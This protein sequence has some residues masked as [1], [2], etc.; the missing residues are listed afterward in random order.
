M[1]NLNIDCN[2]QMSFLPT[3]F[4]FLSNPQPPTPNPPPPIWVGGC[5][6]YRKAT[7]NPPPLIWVGGCFVYKKAT[8]NPQPPTPHLGGGLLRL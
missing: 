6:V 2:M 5:F 4:I 3:S 8:P 1:I 7:P